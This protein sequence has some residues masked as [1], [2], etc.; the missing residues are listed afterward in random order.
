[1]WEVEVNIAIY[2]ARSTEC[3]R[4]SIEIFICRIEEGEKPAYRNCGCNEMYRNQKNKTRGDTGT[5]KM[6]E[7]KRT[8]CV[9]VQ[10]KQL[11]WL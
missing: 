8:M 1:M 2:D 6:R 7:E 9:E 10:T 4:G 11:H 5:E 3:H